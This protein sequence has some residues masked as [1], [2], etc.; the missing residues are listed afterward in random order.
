MFQE[1]F[2]WVLLAYDELFVEWC[3]FSD[4]SANIFQIIIEPCLPVTALHI[5]AAVETT[6][7][8]FI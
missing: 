3:F 8:P 7:S 5:H 4:D 2:T 1:W 6:Q